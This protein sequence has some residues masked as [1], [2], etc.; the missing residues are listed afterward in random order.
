M[1][2]YAEQA[3]LA[4]KLATGRLGWTPEQFWT[5]TPAEFLIAVEGRLAI[6]AMPMAPLAADGLRQLTERFPDG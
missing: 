5:A 1:S 2:H 4:A 3:L 6:Q